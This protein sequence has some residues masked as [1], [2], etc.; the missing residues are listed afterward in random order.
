MLLNFPVSGSNTLISL[1]LVIDLDLVHVVVCKA[2][3]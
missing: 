2:M 3:Q 1:I